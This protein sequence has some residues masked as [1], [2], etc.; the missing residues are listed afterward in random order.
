[1]RGNIPTPFSDIYSLGVVAWQMLSRK[2]PFNGMHI[3]TILY[4]TG[5]GK[6][7]SDYYI[8]DDFQGKYKSLYRKS[9][10]EVPQNR[11]GLTTIIQE[12]EELEAEIS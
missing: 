8:K 2:L 3:H 9:W 1:M 11:P 7:P 10:S 5:K 6:T 4:L 12:L